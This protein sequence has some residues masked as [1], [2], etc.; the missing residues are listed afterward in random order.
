MLLKLMLR[1]VCRIYGFLFISYKI[2]KKITNL[3]TF[4][5][6]DAIEIYFLLDKAFTP[7]DTTVY[8]HETDMQLP[9]RDRDI[10]SSIY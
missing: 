9:D 1:K 5:G 7:L 8:A 2:K 4:I 6:Y 3:S 10:Y